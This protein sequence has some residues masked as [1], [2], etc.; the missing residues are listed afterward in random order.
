MSLTAYNK[1]CDLKNCIE[2]FLDRGQTISKKQEEELIKKVNECFAIVE[3]RRSNAR[4]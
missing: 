4:D 2:L 1:V 3:R